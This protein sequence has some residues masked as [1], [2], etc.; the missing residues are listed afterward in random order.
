MIE[1]MARPFT[2]NACMLQVGNN[3]STLSG[4]RPIVYIA[5][6]YW[7]LTIPFRESKCIIYKGAQNRN[8]KVRNF[9]AWN[10]NF[11]AEIYVFFIFCVTEIITSNPNPNTTEVMHL[12]T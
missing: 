1:R 2:L 12:I 9:S 11:R 3:C 10:K 5:S 7:V 8:Q 4:N 6:K